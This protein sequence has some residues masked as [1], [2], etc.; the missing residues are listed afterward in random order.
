MAKHAVIKS[1]R[2]RSLRWTL[3][4]SRMLETIVTDPVR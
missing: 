3:E 1:D 4:S 2:R